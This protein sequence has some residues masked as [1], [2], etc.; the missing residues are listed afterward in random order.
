MIKILVNRIEP[1]SESIKKRQNFNKILQI[2]ERQRRVF[3]NPWF[4]GVV[5]FSCL[6][7][8]ALIFT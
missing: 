3:H 7:T 5:G 2:H 6:L 4:Y 8:F 1:S